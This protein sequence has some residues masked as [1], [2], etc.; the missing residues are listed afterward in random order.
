MISTTWYHK[1]GSIPI[2]RDLA[3]GDV[4][5]ERDINK[6][7]QTIKILNSTDISFLIDIIF[8]EY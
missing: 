1:N 3:I 7:I 2:G 4:Y 6:S 5:K 8:K